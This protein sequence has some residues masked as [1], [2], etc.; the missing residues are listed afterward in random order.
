M[1]QLALLGHGCLGQENKYSLGRE[2]N[3]F[4]EGARFVCAREKIFLGTKIN[5]RAHENLFACGR[6]FG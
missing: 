3:F 2:K 6:K 4:A 5:F 1:V